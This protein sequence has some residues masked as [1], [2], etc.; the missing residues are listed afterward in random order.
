[1]SGGGASGNVGRQV[2]SAEI[3]PAAVLVLFE[4]DDDFVL[5]IDRLAVDLRR[6][7]APLADGLK[8]GV[9][10][11]RVAADDVDVFQSYRRG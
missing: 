1:M 7:V 4:C 8:R 6:L 2:V 5:R 9:G 10:E 11:N 3:N